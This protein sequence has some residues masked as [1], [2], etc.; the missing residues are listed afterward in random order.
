MYRYIGNKTAVLSPLLE[1]ITA[2]IEPESIF[3]DPMCGTA[4]VAAAIAELG[5]SVHAGDILTFPTYHAHTRLVLNSAPSFEK[6]GCSYGEIIQELNSLPPVS[7]YFS[8]EFAESGSPANGAKPRKYFTGEN[9]SKIDAISN[10]ISEWRNSKLI[11][12]SQNML[13]RHDFIMAVN[14]VANIAG[15]YGHYR[16][17]FSTASQKVLELRESIFNEWASSTNSVF[18]GP[19]EKTVPVQSGSVLYLDPPYMKRQYAA[20]YHL[21]ETVALGDKPSP[22]GESGLRDW[23]PQ[24]SDFCSK[25]KIAY[26]FRAAL[27]D[28][29]FS[30]VFVSYSQDGLIPLEKMAEI[31]SEFGSV[32][33]HSFAHKRFRSNNSP[34]G[35]NLLEYVFEVNVA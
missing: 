29:K 9:A 10:Q 8:R 18:S 4:S 5:H 28:C 33:S 12:D 35:K 13:L 15:T 31:L 24:Y 22:V 3:V 27:S 30:K 7:D 23:W 6:L 11:D 14:R 1:I 20:N 19:V 26:A 17:S 21:L 34:L 16:S 25:R 2:N 32:K